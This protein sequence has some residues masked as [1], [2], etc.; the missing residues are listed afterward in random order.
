[1]AASEAKQRATCVARTALE[2]LRGFPIDSPSVW[3]LPRL[4][5][6]PHVDFRHPC[7]LL[8]GVTSLGFSAPRSNG[9][10]SDERTTGRALP[11][12]DSRA[13]VRRDVATEVPGDPT[14]ESTR[15]PAASQR[16]RRR[17]RSSLAPGSSSEHRIACFA[18]EKP[19]VGAF[20]P[21]LLDIYQTFV[22]LRIPVFVG[23]SVGAM[24]YGEPRA[25]LGLD[26]VIDAG[27]PDGIRITEAFDR[28]RYLLPP[29]PALSRELGRRS[30]G[31]FQILDRA[32]MT[33]AE[34]HLVGQDELLLF[35]MNER[36]SVA[37]GDVSICVPPADYLVLIKL[38]YYS[39]SGQAKHL[40]DIRSMLRVS[41]EEVHTD[42]VSEW[43]RKL[44]VAD[45]WEPIR[46]ELDRGQP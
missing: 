23:G 32:T 41:R 45:T 16:D 25:T 10:D 12:N 40:D 13:K 11:E 24:Y 19:V 26:L 27:A 33:K 46:A 8:H 4:S 22:Q 43:S 17:D 5:R 42:R 2:S 9:F 44:G 28:D 3:R 37:L 14:P 35:G 38:K 18:Q 6:G 30:D 15:C 21:G 31:S 29:L 20:D 34:I 1:M 39:L 7:R 36:S